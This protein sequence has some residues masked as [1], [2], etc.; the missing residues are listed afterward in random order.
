MIMD[1]V[2]ARKTL[3]RAAGL[4]ARRA[5]DVGMG[6]CACMSLLLAAKGFNVISIDR[7]TKAVHEA[8]RKAK[9]HSLRGSLAARL[10][11]AEHMPFRD[12]EFDVVLAYRSLHHARNAERVAREMFRVCR[13]GGV[14]LIA[15]F[16]DRGRHECERARD[17]A[18]L[19][20]RIQRLFRTLATDTER[21]ETNRD[22][23]FVCRK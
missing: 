3:I 10:G 4:P 9:G 8:R 7:S 1:C 19:V 6:G 11:D 17:N 14:V 15:E 20:A 22:T 12:D 5:L 2:Q 21:I 16:N 23:M 18:Q 13:K